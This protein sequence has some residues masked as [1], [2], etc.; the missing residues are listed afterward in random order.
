MNK[1][2]KINELAEYILDNWYEFDD[3]DCAASTF[4]CIHCYMSVTDDKEPEDIQ[5]KPD[6]A[7]IKASEWGEK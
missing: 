3:Y 7:V 1:Q 2:E 4:T 5:H 6:C